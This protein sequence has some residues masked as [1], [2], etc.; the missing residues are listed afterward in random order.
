[1]A[2]NPLLADDDSFELSLDH[3]AIDF[4]AQGAPSTRYRNDRGLRRSQLQSLISTF[5]DLLQ[6]TS[7]DRV[8][9][10]EAVNNVIT[11]SDVTRGPVRVLR[12]IG[13]CPVLTRRG[14]ESATDGEAFSYTSGYDLSTGQTLGNPNTEIPKPVGIGYD[15]TGADFGEDPA[16]T[17][18]GTITVQSRD[19]F[20]WEGDSLT[21]RLRGP[22]P[23]SAYSVTGDDPTQ[24]R[25]TS[26][27][28]TESA[29]RL[30]A[31]S[32]K[33]NVRAAIAAT[34]YKTTMSG[35][36]TV[37]TP[38]RWFRPCRRRHARAIAVVR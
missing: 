34:A 32:T 25:L 30:T 8:L 15:F 22:R 35:P 20:Q 1:M 11:I 5:N 10:I 12:R 19:E 33:T 27:R 24:G 28:W 29:D 13:C 36:T 21:V 3:V 7:S 17:A 26:D 16:A 38:T 31:R 37:L 9:K 4:L 14:H 18:T 6:A 23:L 2:P